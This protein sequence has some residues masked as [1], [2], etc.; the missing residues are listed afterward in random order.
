[1][2]ILITND[3]G[4]DA[5][6]LGILEDAA[7]TI[8]DD[9]WVVAPSAEQS[10]QSRAVTLTT[11]LRLAQLGEKRFSVNGTPADCVVMALSV[12]L[13]AKPD[14]VLSGVNQGFNVSSDILYS[15]TVGAAMEGMQ[16]GVRAI[17]FSQAY[18]A[19]RRGPELWST[20]RAYTASTLSQLLKLEQSPNQIWNVN[21]PAVDA[22]EVKGLAVTRQGVRA[23]HDVFTD[24]RDDGRGNSYH[25]LRF[26]RE[27]GEPEA[28]T[29]LA[30]LAAGQISVTPLGSDLT[31]L[32][33]LGPLASALNG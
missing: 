10:G 4:I 29:D 2:R 12:A 13:D 9:V 30:A 5:A 11:P 23:V 31:A 18:A 33:T 26:R 7:R 6:G 17:A 24:D 15:G 1:M 20:A 27:T 14:L 21:F 3:D 32:D 8:S 25:W 19:E 22:Q 28:G 16:G